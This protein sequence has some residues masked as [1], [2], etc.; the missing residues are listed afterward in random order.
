L[1]EGGLAGRRSRCRD[2][3]PPAR[4]ARREKPDGGADR[5]DDEEQL[6]HERQA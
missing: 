3:S 4:I 1:R 2:R 5:D 6:L